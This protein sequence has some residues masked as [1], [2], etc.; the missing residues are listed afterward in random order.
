MSIRK[1]IS[2]ICNETG[3]IYKSGKDASIDLGIDPGNVCRNLKGSLKQVGG[4]TFAYVDRKGKFDLEACK[5]GREVRKVIS[6]IRKR[7]REV[8]NKEM[9]STKGLG[10]NSIQLEAHIR[11]LFTDG[12][13]LSNRGWGAGKWNVDHIIPLSSYERDAGGGWDTHSEYNKKLIHYTNLRP[14]WHEDN[15]DKLDNI[16]ENDLKIFLDRELIMF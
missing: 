4:Y 16:D 2:V 10:C 5:L 11:S 6:N 8:I 12:M 7:H 14:M 3:K 9:S 13:D 15:M 1:N